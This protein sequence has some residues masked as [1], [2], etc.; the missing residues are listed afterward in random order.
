M[1]ARKFLILDDNASERRLIEHVLTDAFPEAEISQAGDAAQAGEMCAVLM[2]DCVLLDYHMP[3]VDGVVFAQ[4]LRA[5]YPDLPLVLVTGV[6]DE[7][8]VSHAIRCGVSDYLPK[9]RIN[10]ESIRRTVERAMHSCA[11]KRIIEEQR[12]ELE[13]FAYALAHD[14]KQPI[15]QIRTFTQMIAEEIPNGD[16]EEL[17]KHLAF[18]TQAA[19][20]LSDLVDVM[21]QYTLLNQEPD[22]KSVDVET[23]MANVRIAVQPEFDERGA[24][25][26]F[27]GA[28]AVHGN[29]T[30][31]GQV[32]QN[33]VVNGLKYNKSAAPRVDVRAEII[34][35]DCVISVHDNG[36]GIEEQYLT[37]I[38]R[39]LMRLHTAREY[40][41]TG[42]GLTLARKAVLS[43]RGAIWCES[44]IGRGSTFFVRIP[45][46]QAGFAARDAA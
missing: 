18:L 45:M 1:S 41:G 2:F 12:E 22:L 15:R 37:E 19:G 8:L 5:I 33:L 28:A 6:G 42:L 31:L 32:L 13:N 35:K 27:E 10:V 34:E 24:A 46:A 44:E 30:L 40:A 16:S 23:V 11:L 9:S 29:E 7:M 14:F 17:Q 26:S 21:S 20:R 36:I 4:E 25:L 39:P 3:K 38:F 43:Q